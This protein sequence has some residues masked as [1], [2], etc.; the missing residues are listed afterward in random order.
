MLYTCSQESE[1]HTK[2]VF[3]H[4]VGSDDT[5]RPTNG[6]DNGLYAMNEFNHYAEIASQCTEVGEKEQGKETRVKY[7]NSSHT[8]VCCFSF[9]M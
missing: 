3:Y 1:C 8:E 5:I 9:I 2:V 6:D 4:S 7:K